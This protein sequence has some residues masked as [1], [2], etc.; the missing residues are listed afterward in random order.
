MERSD[1]ISRENGSVCI[2][3]RDTRHSLR[4]GFLTKLFFCVSVIY[5]F[6]LENFMKFDYDTQN[7]CISNIDHNLI[8]Y[9]NDIIYQ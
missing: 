9:Q 3:T 8:V 6:A 7:L 1:K 2:R 5:I 4:L